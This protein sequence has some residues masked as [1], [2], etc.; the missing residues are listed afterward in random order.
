MD[1]E[2]LERNS[3]ATTQRYSAVY[4]MYILKSPLLRTKDSYA[5]YFSTS[6]KLLLKR[7][8]QI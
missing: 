2:K 3:K 4:S 6:V 1:K 7:I 8:I 5:I